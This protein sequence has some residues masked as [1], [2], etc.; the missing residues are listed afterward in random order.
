MWRIRRFFE[1]IKRIIEYIPVLWKD[2]DW[3]YE[4]TI[5][6]LIYK[7]ERQLRLWE[8]NTSNPEKY[9][10][11]EGDEDDIRW[12]KV[13]ISLLKKYEEQYYELE[14]YDDDL[15]VIEKEYFMKYPN[16]YKRTLK[17]LESNKIDTDNM[18]LYM[19]YQRHQRALN[20]AFKILQTYGP[21]W[22]N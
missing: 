16:D 5:D 13:F 4:Y 19:G 14:M 6:M 10:C 2:H 3:D 9:L 1:Q 22:W 8:R 18:W 21:G 17:Y 11:H 20:L 7:T 15:K 12:M